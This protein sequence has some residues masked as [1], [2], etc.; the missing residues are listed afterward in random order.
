MKRHRKADSIGLDTDGKKAA[1]HFIFRQRNNNLPQVLERDF[2]IRIDTKKIHKTDPIDVIHF[3]AKH[4][5]VDGKK[6]LLERFFSNAETEVANGGKLDTD[7]LKRIMMAT[8]EGAVF[9]AGSAPGEPPVD[10]EAPQLGTPKPKQPAK[11]TFALD[12]K[13]EEAQR[14][15]R[16][17]FFKPRTGGKAAAERIT[18]GMHVHF[19]FHHTD[20]GNAFSPVDEV[21]I[22]ANDQRFLE[23]AKNLVTSMIDQG[24][25]LTA[26]GLREY[27][28][29]SNVDTL[30]QKARP[31][32]K[33][34]A[35][36][37]VFKSSTAKSK[38][39]HYF[40][41]RGKDQ[42]EAFEMLK[43]NDVNFLKGKAGTGKSHLA[44]GFGVMK[45]MQEGMNLVLARSIAGLKRQQ[46]GHLP[47]GIMDKMG[48][49]VRPLFKMLHGM[50]GFER[51]EALMDDGKILLA[52]LEFIRGET[53]NKSIVVLDEGQNAEKTSM[54]DV[55]TRLGKGSKS[56]V[57]GDPA[58]SDLPRAEQGSMEYWIR[59]M[60][61]PGVGV[62]TL[63]T[64]HRHPLV[65]RAAK[66]MQKLYDEQSAF[67][68]RH[69][70]IVDLTE[71]ELTHLFA[72]ALRNVLPLY[73][74][75][76]AAAAPAASNGNTATHPVR[77]TGN[78][79]TRTG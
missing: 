14:V 52:P 31:S 22:S 39:N 5:L 60:E 46:M 68:T 6:E 59:E 50:L 33:A 27:L 24:L 1:A 78:G 53:F 49:Y 54:G 16:T 73:E 25:R 65:E 2:D 79:Q 34:P 12:P 63:T 35:A 10:A 41:P 70:Q 40:E 30:I 58:Q 36:A 64:N 71:R 19:S 43:A 61:G 74:Q 13:N 11:I 77:G 23:P 37:P 66:A 62:A 29:T 18:R 3:D 51:V 67:E 17:L 44:V 57:T 9:E 42:E 15:A 45:M 69:G 32:G 47:G 26:L 4:T 75:A 8:R 48:P 72:L 7:T 76:K 20:P 28:T 55:L 21:T 56:I 38:K